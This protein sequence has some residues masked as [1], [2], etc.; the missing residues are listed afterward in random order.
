ML[1]LRRNNVDNGMYGLQ[2][3]AQY[4]PSRYTQT[5]KSNGVRASV[6]LLY[7]PRDVLTFD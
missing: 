5:V 6:E 1:H 2:K 4:T 3:A 7:I